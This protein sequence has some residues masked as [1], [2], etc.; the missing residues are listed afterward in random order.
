MQMDKLSLE[1]LQEMMG[2]EASREDA[3]SMMSILSRECVGDTSAVAESQWLRWCD[4][5]VREAKIRTDAMEAEYL[6]A[7][8]DA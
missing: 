5:A 2:T 7:Q 6:D 3:K 1:R 4:E 8:S